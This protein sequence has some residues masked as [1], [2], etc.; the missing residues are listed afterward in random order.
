MT[1]QRRWQL[2]RRAEGRCI[3]CGRK[4]NLYKHHCDQCNGKHL[5][6]QRKYHGHQPW[7]AGFAGRPPMTARKMAN[8]EWGRASGGAL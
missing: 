8:S 7:R 4:R 6:Y 2:K 5:L 3:T 1:R